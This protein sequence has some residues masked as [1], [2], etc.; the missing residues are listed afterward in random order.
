MSVVAQE[1]KLV[2]DENRTAAQASP[3][4]VLQTILAQL[5]PGVQTFLQPSDERSVRQDAKTK[6]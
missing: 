4:E 2:G 3:A 1:V 5:L 6:N